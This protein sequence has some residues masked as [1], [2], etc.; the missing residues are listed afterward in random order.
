MAHPV[1]DPDRVITVAA[2]SGKVWSVRAG[3]FEVVGDYYRF[4]FRPLR[5]PLGT[6]QAVSIAADDVS[7]VTEETETSHWASR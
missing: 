1:I 5:A 3:T 6:Y 2:R 7:S 4:E